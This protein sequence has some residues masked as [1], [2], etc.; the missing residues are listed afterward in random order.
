MTS[1][2]PD[3]PINEQKT[4]GIFK[5]EVAER[6]RSGVLTESEVQKTCD[7]SAKT[8]CKWRSE[9]HANSRRR[10]ARK[11]VEVEIE[12]ETTSSPKGMDLIELNWRGVELI[13]HADYPVGRLA[14]LIRQLG[15]SR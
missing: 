2:R 12:P 5:R 6:I 11:F 7:V 9:L 15:T 1:R 14:D 10:Q 13:V 4:G 8:T 3:D